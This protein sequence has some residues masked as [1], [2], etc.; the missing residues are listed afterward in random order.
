MGKTASDAEVIAYLDSHTYKETMDH[1]N[2]S[3]MTIA[4]I[5]KRN[6][7]QRKSDYM[8]E[9]IQLAIVG[10][11]NAAS[12]LIQGIDYYKTTRKPTG[13]LRPTLAGYHISDIQ[14]VAAFDIASSKV[15]KP[16][17]KAIKEN[18]LAV[19]VEPSADFDIP[20]L[21]GNPLDGYIE[22]TK[23][24]I[25][26]AN[27]APVDVAKALKDS[28]AEIVLC[29]LPSGADEAVKY[30]AEQSLKAGCAFI[31]ATPTS[32]ATD[33]GF[34]KRYQDAGLPL[35]GDDL[36]DQFGATILHKLILQQMLDRGVDIK[37][38]YALDVGGGSESLNTIFRARDVKRAIKSMSVAGAL[39]IDAP[40]VAGTSD[41][42]E[43]LGNGRNSMLWIVG[44]GFLGSEII[45]DVKI[46]TEDGPNGGSVLADVIRATKVALN[47]GACG[48][49]DEISAYGFKKPP[50]SVKNPQEA[51]RNLANFILGIK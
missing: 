45:M 33:K 30:Y 50:K 11:G 36:Q 18:E 35:I 5:K 46:Q 24:I 14:V 28:N 38:S 41:Y 37:E 6:I 31:N 2:I 12:A 7:S 20:V 4:R 16:V 29:L 51:Y 43:H 48:A 1:F 44:K 17:G 9:K 26:P 32:I 42:V 8:P 15:G 49:L 3:R 39:N 19:V 27:I 13:L 22:E 23:D 25:K 40:I 21:M 34:A 47:Q 10:L